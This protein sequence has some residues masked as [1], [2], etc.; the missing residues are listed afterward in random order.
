M[1]FLA[2][3][4]LRAATIE[5]AKALMW[6]DEIGSLEAGKKAD[7]ILFDLDHV[8]WTPFYDPLQAL[9]FS[10]SS[11]SIAETWVDGVALFRDDKVRG[12]DEAEIRRTARK[13]AA[14]AL[15]RAGLNRDD[16]PTTT[17]LYDAGN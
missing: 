10:A 9:V 16:V 2:R 11:A 3:Q 8:E 1:F 12:V 7:F 4:A 5:G 17:T 13:L 6:D 14:A 15:E